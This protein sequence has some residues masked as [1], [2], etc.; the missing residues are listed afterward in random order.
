MENELGEWAWGMSMEMSMGV[1]MRSFLLMIEHSFFFPSVIE[2]PSA[3][4]K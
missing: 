1:G 2:H 4:F 3:V